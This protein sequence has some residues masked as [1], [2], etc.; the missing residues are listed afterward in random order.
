MIGSIP[1]LRAVL[2]SI[3]IVMISALRPFKL[4]SLLTLYS[5]YGCA[6]RAG[7]AKMIT[8]QCSAV[9]VLLVSMIV[10]SH[11]VPLKLPS[12]NGSATDSA[13]LFALNR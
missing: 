12:K 6:I 9:G 13:A 2:S 8:L 7:H 3:Y 4:S 5:N 1:H 11:A 10:G